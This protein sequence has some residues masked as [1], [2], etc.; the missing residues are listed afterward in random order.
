MSKDKD[1]NKIEVTIKRKIF[2]NAPEK[3]HFVLSDGRKLKNVFELIDILDTMSDELFK[4]HVIE[5]KNDFSNWIKD[6]FEEN[7]LADKLSGIDNKVATQ[8]ALLKYLIKEL[9]HS[10]N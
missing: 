9:L 3:Y 1:A 7:E 2:G 8:I 10:Q 6:V 5:A 4:S